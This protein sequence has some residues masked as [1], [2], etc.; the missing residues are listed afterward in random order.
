M[1]EQIAQCT[2]LVSFSEELYLCD[3]DLE[4]LKV[5]KAKSQVIVTHTI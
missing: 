1:K 3:A 2:S 4:V 5:L